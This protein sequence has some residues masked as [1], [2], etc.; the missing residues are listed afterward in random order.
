M[1]VIAY[2]WCQSAKT[3]PAL[4]CNPEIKAL[5]RT[6]NYVRGRVRK[7]ERNAGRETRQNTS[8]LSSHSTPLG[9]SCSRPSPRPRLRVLLPLSFCPICLPFFP[10]FYTTFFSLSIYLIPCPRP[11][12]CRSRG[13]QR[14]SSQDLPPTLRTRRPHPAISSP[15]T[16]TPN[17]IT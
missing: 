5:E 14:Q 16:P 10:L 1:I 4:L 12:A 6:R 3:V 13:K 9:L 8:P 11:C 17:A 7:S 15:P 2:L